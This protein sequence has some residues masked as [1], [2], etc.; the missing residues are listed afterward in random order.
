MTKTSNLLITYYYNGTSRIASRVGGGFSSHPDLTYDPL[1]DHTSTG[2]S[3]SVPLPSGLG[4]EEKSQ[5]LSTPW[6]RNADCAGLNEQMEFSYSMDVS[7]QF[8]NSGP[9]GER[10]FY[11]SDHLGSSQLSTTAAIGQTI[12]SK[13]RNQ[14][15]KWYISK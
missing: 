15:S 2:L 9:D 5:T 12:F 6:T 14:G 13:F 10:Y 7:Y 11:H 3:T 4:Y 1:N 8:T